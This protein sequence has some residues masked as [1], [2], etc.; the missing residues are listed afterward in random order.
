ML[1]VAT[2]NVNGIRAA[3]RRGLKPWLEQRDPDIV[4]FQEMRCGLDDVPNGLFA[5]RHLEFHPGNLAGR[6]GVAIATRTEPTDVRKGFGNRSFDPEGRYL[7][8][9]LD[10][11]GGGLTVGSL[12][13][14]KGA[15]REGPGADPEKYA[16]KMS[17]MS[18]FRAYLTRARRDAQRQGRE[19]L[20]VGDFNIAHTNQDVKNWRG[21]QKSEGFL[22]EERE[23]FGTILGP[24]TL[25]DVV[26]SLHPEVNGPYSWWSWR[27]QA[28]DND[29]GW[30]IDYHLS[31]PTLAGTALTA[32]TDKDPSYDTRISDH[33]PVVVD[34]DW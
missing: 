22:P 6:N 18:S 14:P 10:L 2:I 8:V 23:W 28:F 12:Y 20:V 19:F 32:G 26:R 11:P 21:N 25:V 9:D 5:G 7:E 3:H 17:F 15:V 13:L 1:R 4:A 34:Y 16:R 31:T 29:A 24:R 27:G 30:R 33:A